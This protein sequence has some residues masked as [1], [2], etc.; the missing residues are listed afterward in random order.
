MR[1]LT[2]LEL[3]HRLAMLGMTRILRQRH[4][5]PPPRQVYFDDLANVHE[6]G[7]GLTSGH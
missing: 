1:L 6:S 3:Q 2:I 7:S 4:A 5:I